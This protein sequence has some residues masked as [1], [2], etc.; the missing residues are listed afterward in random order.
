MSNAKNAV[1]NM[2]LEVGHAAE[3][4]RYCVDAVVL[5]GIIDHELVISRI[6]SRMKLNFNWWI[7]RVMGIVWGY[8]ADYGFLRPASSKCLK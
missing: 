8:V 1:Y 4:D 2:C 6:I 3:K 5:S 7:Y